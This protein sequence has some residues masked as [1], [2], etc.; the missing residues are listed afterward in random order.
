MVWVKLGLLD[1]YNQTIMNT[2]NTGQLAS[3]GGSAWD[4]GQT[5]SNTGRPVLYGTGVDPRC[6]LIVDEIYL[7]PSIVC[8]VTNSFIYDLFYLFIYLFGTFIIIGRTY[9]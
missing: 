5:A 4:A 6:W 3:S 8:T 2:E 9:N 1:V 7:H